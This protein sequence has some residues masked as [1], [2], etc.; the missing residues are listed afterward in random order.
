[1]GDKKGSVKLK[2]KETTSTNKERE[3]RLIDRSEASEESEGGDGCGNAYAE[4]HIWWDNN[5]IRLYFYSMGILP[6]L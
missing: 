1:M 3:E 4:R 2:D 5:D 6:N